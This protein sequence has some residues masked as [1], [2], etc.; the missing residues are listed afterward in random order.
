MNADPVG[1]AA[2]D[3]ALAAARQLLGQRR[4]C[5]GASGRCSRH[6]GDE[7]ADLDERA[8]PLGGVAR[9]GAS[10]R[11]R[12]ARRG[13]PAMRAG[14]HA[15]RSRPPLAAGVDL[16]VH[17]RRRRLG[18]AGVA[19]EA[20]HGAGLDLAAVHGVG[21]ERRQVGV[22]ERVAG[23][24]CA[25]TGGCRRSASVPTRWTVPSATASTGAPNGGE[26]VVALVGAGVGAGG[27]EVVGDGRPCRRRGT[28]SA[29]RSGACGPWG[30]CVRLGV[31]FA[32]GFGRG[33]RGGRR[34]SAWGWR[35]RRPRRWRRRPRRGPWCPRAAR[36]GRRRGSARARCV[37]RLTTTRGRRRAGSARSLRT[38]PIGRPSI[39]R[40]ATRPA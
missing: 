20:E 14:S 31:F 37:P 19:G 7:V 27:A 28:R 12:G 5:S 38:S 25:A 29:G 3:V 1:H 36:R 8:G 15:G 18:V 21:R 32:F 9:R 22:E 2:L 4:C 23:G 34:R 33:G 35:R 6:S 13:A 24:R 10:A 16:E 40:P 39:V 17:V 30:R 26:D 11:R